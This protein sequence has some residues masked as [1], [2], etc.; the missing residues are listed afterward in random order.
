MVLS[1]Y[2]LIAFSYSYSLA[3]SVTHWTQ[4]HEQDINKQSLTIND[5]LFIFF[6]SRISMVRLGRKWEEMHESGK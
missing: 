2:N 4:T 1:R 3:Q 5:T 6:R